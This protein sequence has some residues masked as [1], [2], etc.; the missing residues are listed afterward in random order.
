MIQ[1]IVSESINNQ[2]HHPTIMDPDTLH[3]IH[4]CV[5]L[6]PSDDSNIP[7][8]NE[9]PETVGSS[10]SFLV[11][12]PS[13]YWNPGAGIHVRFVEIDPKIKLD[14]APKRVEAIAREWEKVANVRFVFDNAPDAPVRVKLGNGNG[15]Y[16]ALGV[17]CYHVDPNEPTMELLLSRDEKLLRNTVLH[18]FGH[19][20]GCVH[21]HSSPV[22]DIVWKEQN[23]Y[24]YYKHH[25]KWPKE[26]VDRQILHRYEEVGTNHTT[27][28]KDSIMIYPLDPWFMENQPKIPAHDDLSPKDERFI[29]EI[30]PLHTVPEKKRVYYSWNYRDWKRGDPKNTARVNFDN[31]CAT[32]PS[33]AVGFVEFDVSTKVALRAKATAA[34]LTVKGFNIQTETWDNSTLYSGGAL[35][36]KIDDPKTSEFQTGTFDTAGYSSPNEPMAHHKQTVKFRRS[37]TSPPEVVLWIRGF[38]I[39]P[40]L[41]CKLRV[42]AHNVTANSFR[43]HID[44]GGETK[45]YRAIATWIAYPKGKQGVFSGIAEA[46][47]FTPWPAQK[48]NTSG[49]SEVID[50]SDQK[51][52]QSCNASKFHV[53]SGISSFD[54]NATNTVRLH[55][56]AVKLDDIDD[57]IRE[58]SFRVNIE[59]W[60]NSICNGASASYLAVYE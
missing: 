53:Y 8:N 12:D 16:S 60:N 7:M 15:G 1:T 32:I 57:P 20:L 35:W 55:T 42:S 22:S 47:K 58:N 43:L 19:V 29:R 48:D 45:L 36:F 46:K 25:F 28:D 26:R 37:F 56:K 41:D 44:A 5:V 6:R 51:E 33:I 54:F 38:F 17:D 59:T 4:S 24:S 21:E 9:L 40:G 18:E 27:F 31:E 34:C 49:Y 50:L 3:E 11:L 30:Y 2:T 14:D 10:P 13:F 39:G 23:V 52:E